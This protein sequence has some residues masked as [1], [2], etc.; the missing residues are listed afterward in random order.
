ME[1]FSTLKEFGQVV[2]LSPET[3]RDRIKE[4]R[5]EAVKQYRGGNRDDPRS[6]RWLVSNEAGIRFI[7]SEIL[8][9]MTA[10]VPRFPGFMRRERDWQGRFLSTRGPWGN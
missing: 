7:Q 9:A 3:L 5:L 4:G 10:T 6:Y 8:A 1:R 2:H